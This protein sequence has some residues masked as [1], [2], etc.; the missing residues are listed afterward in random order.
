MKDYTGKIV[1]AGPW[2]GEFGWEL[3]AWHAYLRAIKD[4]YKTKMVVICNEGAQY[5]YND[6]ADEFIFY[7]PPNTGESDSYFR[8][9]LDMNKNLLFSI[10]PARYKN[11]KFSW[12][13]PRRIGNP[14]STG[15]EETVS[16]GP[17]E[18][19]PRY[20]VLG[21]EKGSEIDI[22][23]HARNRKLRE[24]DNWSVSNWQELYTS[25]S[26]RYIIGSIGTTDASLHVE[27]TLDL[28]DL[29]LK[30]LTTIIRGSKAVLGP[31]SGPM[32]LASLCECPHIVWGSRSLSQDR[33]ERTWN[34]H[35]TDVIFLDKYDWHPPPEYIYEKVLENVV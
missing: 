22:L 18:I 2:V 4:K 3:F 5:L 23:F 6:F 24:Q 13:P 19:K 29:D 17:F 21:E 14:P 35:A 28:R 15:Y 31:S 9:G 33:Y 10:L 32:H 25:L 1:I 8:Y 20:R 30:G 12:L 27:G 7:T 11:I 34:P 16:V 26:K